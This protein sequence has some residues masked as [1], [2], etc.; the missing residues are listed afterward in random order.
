MG[1]ASHICLAI[2]AF[3]GTLTSPTSSSP[4]SAG[5]LKL[6]YL[7]QYSVLPLERTGTDSESRTTAGQQQRE[8]NNRCSVSDSRDVQTRFLSTRALGLLGGGNCGVC[9]LQL[10][11]PSRRHFSSCLRVNNQ[12]VTSRLTIQGNVQTY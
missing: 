2:P 6:H 7:L 11:L 5:T 12:P 4:A 10:L 8:T 9:L 3:S 1:S